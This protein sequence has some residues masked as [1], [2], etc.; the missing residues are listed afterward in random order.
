MK[1]QVLIDRE[2]RS[3]TKKFRSKIACDREKYILSAMSGTELVPEI[4]S[5]D[6]F[7]ICM[8]MRPGE[9]ISRVI[10][11]GE[12]TFIQQAFEKLAFSLAEFEKK[13]FEKTGERVYITDFNPRNFIFDGEKVTFIDFEAA[14]IGGDGDNFSALLAMIGNCRFNNRQFKD[15]LLF[16]LRKLLISELKI[17]VTE[18]K[19]KEKILSTQRQRN[20]RKILSR[21]QGFILAGGKSVRMKG[22]AKGFLPLGKFTFCDYIIYGMQ[23]FD[24]V[25]IS[26]NLPE[27]DR[28]GLPVI[29]DKYRDIGPLSGLYTALENCREEWVFLCPCD[30]PFVGE[31]LVMSA[32]DGGDFSLDRVIFSHRGRL[33]PTLGFYNIKVLPEVK[34]RINRGEY[35]LTSLLERISYSVV[36][37]SDPAAGQNINTA[38]EYENLI[39]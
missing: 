29:R 33:Y 31:K 11:G 39:K 12:D 22:R 20:A 38:E 6:D 25:A 27:Y 15:K 1:N 14:Q 9:S 26:A 28:Y 23:I 16:R 34:N 18:S 2:N 17:T 10:D 32:F 24:S 37:I 4:I 30:M 3:V 13:F 7:S 8:S 36:E 21:T 5:A 35:R 19:I